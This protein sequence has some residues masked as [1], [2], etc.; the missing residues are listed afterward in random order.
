MSPKVYKV[1]RSTWGPGPSGS[2]LQA[3][4]V[5]HSNKITGVCYILSF[6]MFSPKHMVEAA[7]P[8]HPILGPITPGFES[9]LSLG[10]LG[11]IKLTSGKVL[12][13]F[14]IINLH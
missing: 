9:G 13:N 1:R 14:I 5:F 7:E 10:S 6:I 4:K 2:R 11:V 3:K 12:Y 8:L